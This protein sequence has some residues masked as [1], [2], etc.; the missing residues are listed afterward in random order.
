MPV[1]PRLVE[2]IKHPDPAKRKAAVQA[3]AK[4][5]DLDA[6]GALETAAD[7]DKDPE[8]R[9]LAEK[10]IQYVQRNN[11]T[12]RT[13]EPPQV[14]EQRPAITHAPPTPIVEDKPAPAFELSPL[15]TLTPQQ[16]RM[17]HNAL[18]D[19]IEMHTRGMMDR[20]AKALVQ[21]FKINPNFDRDAYARSAVTTI[22]G[23]PADEAIMAIRSGQILTQYKPTKNPKRIDGKTGS[24]KRGYEAD[25]TPDE[26]KPEKP[27]GFGTALVDTLIYAALA[28]IMSIG[29]NFFLVNVVFSLMPPDIRA[30]INP[31]TGLTYQ[32]TIDQLS[33][34]LTDSLL[35][36]AV[37]AFLST[38]I[39]SLIY[40]G[41]IHM[42]AKIMGG[43]GT[44]SMML[45]RL[46]YFYLLITFLSVSGVALILYLLFN[47]LSDPANLQNAPT[48]FTIFQIGAIAL[49]IYSLWGLAARIG[50]NYDF[51]AARGCVTIILSTILL[52][53]LSCGLIYLLA[54][55]AGTDLLSF[56]EQLQSLSGGASF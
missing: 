21:A 50:K 6:L 27:V 35:V 4:T 51:G 49:G 20:S 56:A 32:Q 24:G 17:A 19:A 42:A 53:V 33:I 7:Y 40:T 3:L 15:V 54:N 12:D 5:K 48:Y 1:D 29:L 9:A 55:L 16:E 8:I 44:Y 52:I 23:L 14:T 28:T 34:V 18:S 13:A 41:I 2:L 31:D 25:T 30:S 38:L 37:S 46:A 26:K 22:T 39:S 47:S 36:T 45:H 10:A 43:D 11:N